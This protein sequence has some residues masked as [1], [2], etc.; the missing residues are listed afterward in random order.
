MFLKN[1]NVQIILLGTHAV[2]QRLPQSL[3]TDV[4]AVIIPKSRVS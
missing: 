1:M 2:E 4:L 3:Q